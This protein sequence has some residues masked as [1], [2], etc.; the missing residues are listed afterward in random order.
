MVIKLLDLC[1]KAG[2]CS[3][4]Y[5]R[6]AKALGLDIEI[7]GIDKDYQPN[8]PF[9]FIQSDAIYYLAENLN[10]FDI[11]H[12]SPPCQKYTQGTAPHRAKG[13]VYADI[14]NPIRELFNKTEKPCIIE[15]VPTAPIRPDVVLTGN[16]FGLK[17]LRKRHFELISWF[18][19][20]PY[21][22]QKIGSVKDGD[23]ACI[24]GKGAYR[25]SQGDAMPKFKQSSVVE[26]WSF[27][28]GIDW[29][30]KDTELAEAIP[31]AYTEYIGKQLFKTL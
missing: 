23:F 17:V 25:K 10:T 3:V 19:L 29:M 20:N 21:I 30:K 9:T 16:M 7:V 18:M 6:A 1:C 14:I 8:Y 2:G 11:Y 31:P 24:F 15:N 4:G 26:T 28:M 13:K 5:Y 12:A 22:P 27:A